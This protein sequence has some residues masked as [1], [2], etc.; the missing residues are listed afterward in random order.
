MKNITF[1]LTPDDIEIIAELL[2]EHPSFDDDDV[3]AL[4]GMFSVLAAQRKSVSVIV[5]EDNNE[6]NVSEH[7]GDEDYEVSGV[8]FDLDI[9]DDWGSRWDSSLEEDDWSVSDMKDVDMSDEPDRTDRFFEDTTKPCDCGD[10]DCD[11][12]CGTCNRDEIFYQ[13]ESEDDDCWI[14]VDNDLGEDEPDFPVVN[15][16][17]EPEPVK[18]RVEVGWDERVPKPTVDPN[19]TKSLNTETVD[20]DFSDEEDGF[21]PKTDKPFQD[22]V[23]RF[24]NF[25]IG[26]RN[27]IEGGRP[28]PEPTPEPEKKDEPQP[29]STS[30]TTNVWRT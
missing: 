22:V 28:E 8:E 20:D 14:V 13:G 12:K 23:D 4:T 25:S 6:I 18:V 5:E 24:D 17:V 2:V 1:R 3:C 29:Q 16:P 30:W 21:D 26:V 19:Y 15:E 27:F 10:D 11:G 9:D 7:T